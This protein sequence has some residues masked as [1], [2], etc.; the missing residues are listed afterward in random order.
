[1]IF[2][3]FRMII[4]NS[5]KFRQTVALS[6]RRETGNGIP[7][8]MRME[9]SHAVNSSKMLLQQMCFSFIV[10]RKMYRLFKI[11][12]AKR[13]KALGYDCRRNG[14]AAVCVRGEHCSASS[15]ACTERIELVA[16]ENRLPMAFSDANETGKQ[17]YSFLKMKT[18]FVLVLSDREEPLSYL[19]EV[20]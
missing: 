16:L 2:P 20:N 11:F 8:R 6:V 18:P 13:K 12:M 4:I 14:R 17:E 3:P 7:F 15:V 1:M 19:K 9:R 5:T 10:L